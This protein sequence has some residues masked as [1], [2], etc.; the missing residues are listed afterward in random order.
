MQV[1][2][3][4]FKTTTG[5]FYKVLETKEHIFFCNYRESDENASV[6]MFNREGVIVSDN[7]HAYSH[8]IELI[9]GKNYTKITPRLKKIADKHLSTF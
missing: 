9:E 5:V 2:K 1:L 7:Y 8:F 6:K 3:K 4:Q